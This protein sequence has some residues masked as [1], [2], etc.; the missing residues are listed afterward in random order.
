MDY[1]PLQVIAYERLLAMIQNQ[2]MEFGK[3]YSE[4]KIANEFA[5]SRTP[6]RDALNRLSNEYYIDILPNRGFQLHKSTRSDIYTAYHVRSAIEGYCA[7]LLAHR[8]M[9]ARAVRCIEQMEKYV[10][11][12][13]ELVK[14]SDMDLREYWNC[15]YQFHLC[16]VDYLNVP[17]FNQQFNSFMHFFM[18]HVV[19]NYRALSREHSTLVEHRQ[20]IEALKSGDLVRVQQQTQFHLDQTLKVTLQG[21]EEDIPEL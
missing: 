8:H 18:A 9:D 3:I 19:R 14:S 6:I 13:E 20:I 7:R 2:E 17:A 15:D 5:I 16:M 11:D 4:T 10:R 1:K 21:L 12:Q